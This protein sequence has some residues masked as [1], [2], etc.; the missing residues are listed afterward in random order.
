MSRFTRHA[1]PIPDLL[2]LE[3]THAQDER[4][5][6]SRFFCESEFAGL[7]IPFSVAQINHSLTRQR[8]AVR[9]MHFQLPPHEET[10]FVSCIA[11][12]VFDVAV[13]MR[14]Q[15]PTYLSWHGEILSAENARS[16]LIPR[17]FAHGFQTIE[18][19]SQL[20]YLVDC[21]YAPDFET[22][23]NALDPKISITWPLPIT[24]MSRRDKE[25]ATTGS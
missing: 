21:P 6:F 12:A 15:S 14:P 24:Q 13:D 5:F 3:R 22:G 8:G 9:G 19:D 18:E 16:M 25:L 11:G 10:K 2:V 20:L 1:T 17:G 7:G 4:G 23:V